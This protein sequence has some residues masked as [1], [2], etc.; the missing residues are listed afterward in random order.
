MKF[1]TDNVP[2]STRIR[3]LEYCYPKMKDLSNYLNSKGLDS[4]CKVYDFSPDKIFEHSEHRPYGPNEYKKAE[5]TNLIIRENQEFDY[6]FMFDIDTFFVE[7][8]FDKVFNIVNNIPKRKLYTFDAAKLGDETLNKID[9][10]LELDF[11][12]EPF[13]YAYSGDKDNGPLAFG[14]KGGLGGVYICD[15]NLIIEAGWFNENYIKWGGEDGEMLSRIMTNIRDF[16]HVA[17]RDFAPFHL[18]HYQDWSNML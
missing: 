6:I 12:S 1:W 3:N 5:K 14:V 4:V 8:D 7:S 15:I 17:V 2:N 10:G 11:Y 18:P 13:R 16:E 9:D